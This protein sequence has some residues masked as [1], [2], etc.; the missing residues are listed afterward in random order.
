MFIVASQN[1][2]KILDSFY[3]HISKHIPNTNFSSSSTLTIGSCA[4]TYN[5][6]TKKSHNNYIAIYLNYK[7]KMLN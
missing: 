2:G 6:C 4:G 5:K 7:I 3:K 1:D